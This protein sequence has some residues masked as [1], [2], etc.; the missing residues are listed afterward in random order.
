MELPGILSYLV[1]FGILAGIYGVL[2]LG[3][4]LQWGFTGLFNIG[5]A[6]FFAIGAYAS[7]ILTKP[8]SPEHLG[9]FSLPFPLGLAGAALAAGAIAYLVGRPTLRLRGDYLAIATIGIAETIRLIFKSEAWL[10]YGTRGIRA[11]PQPLYSR[12]APYY[13]LFYLALV[14]IVISLTYLAIER[15]I[16]NPWGRTL[17]AIREDEMVAA[18][19]GKDIFH[20]K[21]Q[22]LVL[23]SAI[24]G[25]GGAL[26]AHYIR[27]IS[28]ESFEPM[29]ATF[30]IWVMLIVGGSGNN[31]GALLGS[32]VVWAIWTGTEFLTD[33]LPEALE[34]RAGY[35]RVI[36]IGLLLQAILL[37]RPQGLLPEP[38]ARGFG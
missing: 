35:L 29:R 19:A 2:S 37:R 38:K 6:G 36:L 1:F 5:V 32:L 26:Y 8:P 20:F 15:L 27:F 3:L 10:T 14:A 13:D 7:A 30:L 16:R 4:N 25:L 21:M 17:R 31:R 24:M 9:G 28:P 12:F 33:L 22:A 18:A 34:T 23:G 11:I